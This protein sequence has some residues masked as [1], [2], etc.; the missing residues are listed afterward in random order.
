METWTKTCG[1][2]G[3]F[4]R[5]PNL[6]RPPVGKVLIASDEEHSK[7]QRLPQRPL[8]AVGHLEFVLSRPSTHQHKTATDPQKGINTKSW[9]GPGTLPDPE[10]IRGRG[11]LLALCSSKM[12][13]S[14]VTWHGQMNV[15]LGPPV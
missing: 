12:K 13:F 10:S 14:T 2:S 9:P 15:H 3:S 5:Q 1:F 4:S 6:S 8:V 7:S 11:V